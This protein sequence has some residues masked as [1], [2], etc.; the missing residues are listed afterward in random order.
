MASDKVHC[1]IDLETLSTRPRAAVISLGYALFNEDGALA[2][3]EIIFDVEEQIQRGRNVEASTV[4]WW[5]SQGESA[6][7]VFEKSIKYGLTASAGMGKFASVLKEHCPNRKNLLVWGNAS[8]FDI[9]LTRD[10][11]EHMA[12]QHWRLWDYPNE[13]CYRTAVN[14][15]DPEKKH[16]PERTGTHHNAMDDA[17]WQ[18]EYLSILN[19][20]LVRAGAPLRIL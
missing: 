20:R 3:D 8:T 18:A 12:P 11:C 15:F 2:A 16:A 7:S 10:L 5:A 9:V 6:K 19:N 14:I 13:R 1:M 17:I 4:A